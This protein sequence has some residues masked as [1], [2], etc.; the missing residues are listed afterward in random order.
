MVRGLWLIAFAALAIW[1]MQQE[2]KVLSGSHLPTARQPVAV[3][4]RGVVRYVTPGQAHR[5]RAIP[6]LLLG[7]GLVYLGLEKFVLRRP[8]RD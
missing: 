3:A 7:T 1:S 6:W 2:R 5:Y 4:T 8:D